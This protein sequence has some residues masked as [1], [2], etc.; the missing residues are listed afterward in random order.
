MATTPVYAKPGD[1]PVPAVNVVT[2]NGHEI[3]GTVLD[4]KTGEP[5]IGVTV[6]VKGK[7]TGVTTDMDGLFKL[8]C[9]EGDVLHISYIGY[10]PK[11]VK[12]SNLKMYMVE[13]SESTEMLEEVVVTA[14]GVGQKKASMVGSVSQIRA[15]E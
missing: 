13:L 11:E 15:E 14:F 9:Q 2:Q 4:A 8:T 3:Q 7:Q 5:L 1:T 6:M 12:V 10:E